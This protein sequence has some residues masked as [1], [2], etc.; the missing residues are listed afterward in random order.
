MSCL[1][2]ARLRVSAPGDFYYILKINIIYVLWHHKLTLAEKMKLLP[3][4]TIP[5]E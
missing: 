4:D 3:G 1:P 5:D 2:A